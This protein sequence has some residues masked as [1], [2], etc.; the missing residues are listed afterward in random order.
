MPIIETVAPDKAVGKVKEVYD[1]VMK[2]AGTIPKPF[3]ML[4][5][6]PDLIGL[7]MGTMDY[8]MQHPTLSFVLLAHIRML[9]ARQFNY[10]YCVEFNGGILQ[11]F[12]GVTE[13]QMDAMLTDP[14]KAPLEERDRAMLLFVLKA[15]G[16]PE[17]TTQADVDAL[18]ELG[19]TD[20]D[21]FDAAAH[22]AGMVQHGTLFKAFKMAE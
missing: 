5:A 18:R 4:S 21:I 20:R 14:A 3:Q 15:V 9:V 22:G 1:I 10:P 8:F 2:R 19:W 12:A 17:A 13:K 11:M 6:S 7:Q 16:T